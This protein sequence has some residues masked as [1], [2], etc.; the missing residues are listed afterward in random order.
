[1]K[2][3]LAV[4]TATIGTLIV[5]ASPAQAARGAEMLSYGDAG[6]GVRCVQQA[7]NI[8]GSALTVDGQWGAR[9]EDAVVSYQS[10]AGLQQ[11]GVVGPQTGQYLYTVLFFHDRNQAAGCYPYLPTT[12]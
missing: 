1:M 3:S 7:L 2:R 8:A 9:T 4:T 6:P 10:R 5:L 11:D 12:T